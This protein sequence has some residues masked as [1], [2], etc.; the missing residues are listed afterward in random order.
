M[1]EH[2]PA[3]VDLATHYLL[4]SLPSL[5]APHLLIVSVFVDLVSFVQQKLLTQPT[6]LVEV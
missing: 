3:S 1:R 2:F 5:C 6:L 4:S